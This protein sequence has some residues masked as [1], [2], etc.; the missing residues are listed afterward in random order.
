VLLLG[1]RKEEKN[2]HK[3]ISVK[4]REKSGHL[5]RSLGPLLPLA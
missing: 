4:R 5:G 2:L 3:Y 1:Y